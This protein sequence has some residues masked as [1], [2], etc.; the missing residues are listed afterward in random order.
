ML[1]DLGPLDAVGV[2]GTVMVLTAYALPQLGRLRPD[3]LAY[4]LLNLV[5]AALIVVSLIETFNL[6]AFLMEAAW[7]LISLFGIWRWWRRRH[8]G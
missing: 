5:G 7:V 3:D 6:S 2:L 4:L 8:A 1:D